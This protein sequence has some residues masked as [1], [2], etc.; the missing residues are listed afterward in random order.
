M[1]KVPRVLQ[2][3]AYILSLGA[4]LI[5]SRAH[6]A[7][8]LSAAE[9]ADRYIEAA[10][11][12]GQTASGREDRGVVKWPI[13]AKIKVYTFPR[14]SVFDSENPSHVKDIINAVD[15]I[16]RYIGDRIGGNRI[17]GFDVD[18]M[19]RVATSGEL[20]EGGGGWSN[21][22]SVVVG[23]KSEIDEY[24]KMLSAHVP[25]VQAAY[26]R[27]LAGLHADAPQICFGVSLTFNDN[28]FLLSRA[29]IFVEDN[30]EQENC[31]YQNIIKMS[32][33]FKL[34]WS[35]IN[36]L[37]ETGKGSPLCELECLLLKIHFDDRISPGM[38][39]L[40]A[41]SAAM[42]ILSDLL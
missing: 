37:A 38:S 25:R 24:V 3:T 20:V 18:R 29:W 9:I 42:A 35:G 40:D 16:A 7:P 6:A 14:D 22:M 5:G 15:S 26:N 34:E 17:V 4:A 28:L 41:R 19:M 23:N 21:S 32:G 39:I 2:A 11:S 33:L 12:A 36:G 1:Q 27:Y 31:V 10:I 13:A 30:E 8:S